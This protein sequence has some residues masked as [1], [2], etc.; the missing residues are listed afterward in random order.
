[1]DINLIRQIETAEVLAWKDIY[2]SAPAGMRENLKIYYRELAGGLVL[3]LDAMPVTHFN[4][5]VG[6]GV[7]EPLTEDVLATIMEGYGGKKPRSFMIL[8]FNGMQ[9]PGAKNM[10]AKFGLE[11]AG[12]WERIYRHATPLP[13]L[14]PN[15][16]AL[17]VSS[18]DTHNANEWAGFICRA[19]GLP[20]QQWLICKVGRQGWH[21]YIARDKTLNIVAARSFF[22]TP[23]KWVWTG[24]EAPVPGIM[25]TNYY[26]DFIIWQ[27]AITSLNAAGAVGYVGDIE[28]I[29]PVQEYESYKVLQ[30]HFGFT[31]AYTRWHY[32]RK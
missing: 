26:P 1:M 8:Y 7:N 31:I 25:T 20:F 18:V 21:H 2:D 15:P 23:G 29:S 3:H 16:Q 19:Y 4:M 13:A 5:A 6:F 11:V 10:F 17:E 24:I 12:G 28:K 14:L 27:H 9:P 22:I 32:T 30:G